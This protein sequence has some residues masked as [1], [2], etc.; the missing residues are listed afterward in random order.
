MIT[1]YRTKLYNYKIEDKKITGTTEDGCTTTQTILSQDGDTVETQT[2]TFDLT[3]DEP[4]KPAE[5]KPAKKSP[6]ADFVSKEKHDPN[7]A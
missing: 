6:L 2:H 7:P 3:K 5:V 4:A 1:K